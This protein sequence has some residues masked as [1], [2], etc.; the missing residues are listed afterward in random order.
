MDLASVLEDIRAKG[1]ISLRAIAASAKR[2]RKLP[3]RVCG[4]IVGDLTFPPTRVSGRRLWAPMASMRMSALDRI[5]S[6][7]AWSGHY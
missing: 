2:A 6:K 5:V 7:L 1:H 3:T 4:M